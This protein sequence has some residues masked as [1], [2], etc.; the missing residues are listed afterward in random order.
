MSIIPAGNN[1]GN[2]HGKTYSVFQAEYRSHLFPG[3]K[4]VT[5]LTND[6][7][8]SHGGKLFNKNT[9]RTDVMNK[10]ITD[11]QESNGL[12]SFKFMGGEEALDIQDVA[13]DTSSSAIYYTLDGVQVEK[14]TQRGI[15]LEQRDGITRKFYIK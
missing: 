10:P 9:D 2:K 5:E 15:Y 12:I 8:Y 4:G 14:P 6:S 3:S 1:Y 7:H 13:N 11:I